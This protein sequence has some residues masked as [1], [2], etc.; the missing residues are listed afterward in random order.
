MK[1]L[2]FFPQRRKRC[3]L[4]AKISCH[5]KV[6][7]L[8]KF[9]ETFLHLFFLF[10]W[11]T[12]ICAQGQRVLRS[13]KEKY[14]SGRCWGKVFSVNELGEGIFLCIRHYDKLR[15]SNET[16][17]FFYFFIFFIFYFLFFFFYYYYYYH[18]A[19]VKRYSSLHTVQILTILMTQ[20][21]SITYRAPKDITYNTAIYIPYSNTYLNKRIGIK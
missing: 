6:Q 7:L 19:Y 17:C 5:F 2:S 14:H 3:G 8:G 18:I 4:P 13:G 15:E 16:T 1:L 9:T 20:I 11:K 10:V 21:F 12:M